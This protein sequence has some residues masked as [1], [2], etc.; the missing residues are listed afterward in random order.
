MRKNVL[1]VPS[2]QSADL[3]K[4]MD[5]DG[6]VSR[7]FRSGDCTGCLSV[8]WGILVALAIQY[9]R[10]SICLMAYLPL[11]RNALRGGQ[12]IR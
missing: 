1:A 8:I 6:C 7:V 11:G 3:V 2:A 12:R 5:H 4:V 9:M 10:E